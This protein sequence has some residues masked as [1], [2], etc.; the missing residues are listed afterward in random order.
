MLILDSWPVMEWFREREPATACFR[1]VL[2]RAKSGNLRLQMSIMNLG[3]VFYSIAKLTDAE[4]TDRVVRAL[5]RLG[6]EAVSADDDLVWR[7]ARL[8]AAFP[9]S[10]GD[11]FAAALAIRLSAKVLT[12]DSEFAALEDAKLLEVEWV[13]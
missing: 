3:E 4:K 1:A 5:V 2:Q 8:K 10:Y 9:L 11:A 6:I 13:R 7:A 12:G